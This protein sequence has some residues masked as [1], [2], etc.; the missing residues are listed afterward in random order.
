[1]EIKNVLQLMFALVFFLLLLF[2]LFFSP[3][4]KAL[5]ILLWLK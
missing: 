4:Y 1:M 2:T 5:K 3:V